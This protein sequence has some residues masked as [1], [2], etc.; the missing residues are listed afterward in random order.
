[1]W[2]QL[3]I[4]ALISGVL[5]AAAS[6]I[7]RRSPGLGGL[8]A[9]LPMTTLLA[10]VWLWRDTQDPAR[11][12]EFVSGTALYVIAALPAFA[13]IALALRGGL[14]FWLA[15]AIGAATAFA[16]YMA[17]GWIGPRLGWPV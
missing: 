10:L 8:I 7:A 9:S 11:A 17:L 16:G 3:A 14:S 5:L 2:L 12:A 15:M 4:Q 1:M 6:E 13:A